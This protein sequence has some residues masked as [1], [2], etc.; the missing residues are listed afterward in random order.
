MK[1][2]NYYVG[3]DIGT[4]SVGYAVTDENYNLQKFKGEPMWGVTLF[5]EAQTT[6][7]RR[8]YR[9]A[10]RRLDRRQQRVRLISELFAAEIQKSDEN[11]FKR[12]KESYLYP[13][14]PDDKVRL[15]DSY[16]KQKEYDKTYPTI[17]HLIVDL[18]QSEE[19]KDVRLVYIACAWL[20]AHRGHFLSEVDKHNVDAVVDFDVVYKRF[21]DFIQRDGVYAIPWQ[22]GVNTVDVADVL[23]KKIGVTRKTKELT[24]VLF[25][26]GKVPK[27]VNEQY[28]FNYALVVKL[29]CGGKVKVKDLFDKEEYDDLEEKSVSLYMDDERL[30]TVLQSIGDDGQLIVALKDVYDW[31]VLVDVLHGKPTVSEAKVT[32]YKQHKQD[33]QTLKRFVR[34]YIPDSYNAVFRSEN[35]TVN[36]VAY[37]GKNKT[38]N[39]KVKAKKS[40]GK[41]DFSK[42]ILSLFKSVT[43]EEADTQLFEDMA[44]RL[45]INSFLPK[46]V[47][48]DNRVIPYQLYWFELNK[49]LENAEQYLP[50]LSQVDSDGITVSDKIRSVFEFR[51]PYYVG[52]LK[53]KSESAPKL[54][55]W[56]VRKAQGDIYPWNFTEKV[57][58]DASEEAFIRRM[59][60]ACSYLPCEDVLPKSSMLYCAFEVL[61]EINNITINGRE[62]P[63]SVKQDIFDDV[64]MNVHKVT[65][66]RIQN[67]LVS[68]NLMKQS[69][70]IGGLDITVKSSLKPFVQFKNLTE[71]GLLTC[72]DVE[73]II[74]RATYSE[75]KLRLSKWIKDNYPTLPES[76]VKYIVGLKLKGFGRL[77]KRF[78]C[79][80]DGI[81]KDTGEIYSS[82][83]RAMWETNCNL[84]QLLSDRFTFMDNIRKIVEEYYGCETANVSQRLDEMYVSN[85]VKR[86]IMRTLDILKDVVKVKGSAPERIFIEMA[87]GTNEEQKGKRTKS[88]LEQIYEFYEKVRDEDIRLLTKQLEDW[89]ESAHNKLQSDKLFLY[90]IQL[91]KCMYTGES[92]DIDSVLSGDGVYNIEHIYP[93]SFVKDDSI[94]NNLI[95]VSSKVNGIKDNNY[96]ISPEIRTKMQGYWAYLHK[97]GLISDEKYKRLIR[98]TPFTAEEKF[99]F[100]NRQLVETRQS[101]KA[102]ATLLNEIYP[103]TEIVY[104]KAGLVSEV[105]QEFELLKSR[106]VN[107]LHHAKDAYL[108]IVAGNVWHCKFSR[109]FW[110]ADEQHNA[111]TETVFNHPVVCNGKTVWNGAAD[112]ERVVKI[113]RK[114]TAHLTMYSY[115][116]HSGQNGGFFDQNPLC[117][118][119]CLVP[120]KKDR[121]TQIYGGYNSPTVS[122]FVL[123]KY[124][125]NKK[126]QVSFVPIKLLNIKEFIVDDKYAMQYIAEELGTKATE[127][128]I[129]LNKRIIKIYTMLS[130]DG[131]CY[132]IRG[133]G[134]TSTLGLMN[135]NPFVT[136]PE[137]A[138]Y[139]KRLERFN[140]KHKKNADL[141][142]DE[143]YDGI[144][145]EGNRRLYDI[146]VQKLSSWPYNTRPGNELLINKLRSHSNDF[147]ELDIFKQVNTL[148]QIQGLFGRIKQADLQD[149]KESA[150]SG[151]IRLSLNLSNWKK[152]YTDVRIIDRSASGIF[153]KV[154]DNLLQLL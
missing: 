112:K 131:A 119:K 30:A 60:N 19:P 79:G 129:L 114:N 28:E 7:D 48:S 107:D 120:L 140:E 2:E 147:S 150:N 71:N 123:V 10:R 26:N 43:P 110:R 141:V 113:A 124:V 96:P 128:E 102:V 98:T 40:V 62:I 95:L 70:V 18:M 89:G 100:I 73:K 93:R 20:V 83:I 52:P 82:V 36:Y 37:I 99:E 22:D 27:N 105:R 90:F 42:Y 121:P 126:T 117:A 46:Q 15:F 125:E 88:R 11:F 139:I 78:L 25:G 29:L 151:L 134:G 87:R 12:I 1:K 85:A 66:K 21:V 106:S 115:C 111:K 72:E 6:A 135:M 31:S 152:N 86:P 53:E 38:S 81:C 91:G 50:F 13:E 136:S 51:V 103:E 132:C 142:W 61:N 74:H 104:V 108:N 127:I 5:D 49:I 130:L 45:Q 84:M 24:D 23:K 35:S 122:G 143:K 76:E 138:L 92:I 80:V 16:E 39:E 3:L 44:A 4:D 14:S 56:M 75:D 148:L 8:A 146:Y 116:K 97:S 33:L 94:I 65:P 57:D 32:V 68:N 9:S 109:R 144:S 54:N 153:E 67:Y 55:H 137:N 59:T 133:K 17:H 101:A 34:K 63:V 41:E 58:L 145:F 47:D 118:A 64:F 154:S 149:L 77:S 69:D